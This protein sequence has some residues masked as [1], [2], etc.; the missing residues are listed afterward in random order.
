MTADHAT[1]PPG[2]PPHA[3]DHY[4]P[5]LPPEPGGGF[6]D[7]RPSGWSRRKL[8]IATVVLAVVSAAVGAGSALTITSMTAG[9]G[10]SLHSGSVERVAAK[11]VP[12]VV[13]LN[14]AAGNQLSEGSGIVISTDGLV[15]TN[16]H[17]IAPPDLS[18]PA[19]SVAVLSDGQKT[20]F[21]VVGADAAE[22]LA[23]I[24]LQG[25]SHATPVR[26]GS[27]DALRVG[28]RV[29]ALGSPLGLDDT[30]TTGIISAL[31]RSLPGPPNAPQALGDAI[32]TDA[33]MNP[34]SSGGPLV[35]MTGALI[36]VNA[37]FAQAG[38]SGTPGGTVGV[39]F[40]IPADHAKQIAQ[41]LVADARG[42]GR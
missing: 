42:A 16:N 12:S 38:D 8:A 24:R 11:V 7:D 32:Q 18:G 23:V 28:Q 39:N 34:G 29:V 25:I 14:I 1:L 21:T 27:S 10:G 33:A 22:D 3:V 36:G 31:H 15:L 19:D 41:Q 30:V 6:R 26:F 5:L 4:G 2:T 9:S 37:G 20:R 13:Q 17:V 40:A 35:D